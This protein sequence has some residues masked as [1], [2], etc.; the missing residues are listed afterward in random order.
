MTAFKNGQRN[1]QRQVANRAFKNG[2]MDNVEISA[3][4]ANIYVVG[5]LYRNALYI[6]NNK[7]SNIWTNA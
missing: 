3:N 4:N 1:H 6:F 2:G 7:Q 5:L